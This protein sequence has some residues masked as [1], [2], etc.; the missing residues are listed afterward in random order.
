MDSTGIKFSEWIREA[1]IGNKTQ[2]IAR[3]RRSSDAKRIL[4]LA[5]KASNNINQIAHN[6]N[7]AKQQGQLSDSIFEVVL[8]ELQAL[9]DFLQSAAKNVD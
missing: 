3:Q 4:F 1:V 8:T 6:L 2:I 7:S 9:N 5:N